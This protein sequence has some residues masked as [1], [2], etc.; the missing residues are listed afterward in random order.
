M[1]HAGPFE[2]NKQAHSP[3]QLACEVSQ[4]IVKLP[5]PGGTDLGFGSGFESLG[6]FVEKK[7]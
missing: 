7:K 3:Q 2:P 6:F 1:S 4:G 5:G